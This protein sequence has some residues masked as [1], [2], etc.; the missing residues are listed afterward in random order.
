MTSIRV[1]I[2]ATLYHQYKILEY[3]SDG[4]SE[5]LEIPMTET[6]LRST[7]SDKVE[8]YDPTSSQLVGIGF[9]NKLLAHWGFDPI[10]YEDDNDGQD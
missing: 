4:T 3:R 1:F 7:K 5:I 9:A 8:Y 2:K 6:K 10:R